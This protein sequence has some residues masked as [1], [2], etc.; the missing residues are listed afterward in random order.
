VAGA[1]SLALPLRRRRAAEAPASWLRRRALR[2]L[3]PETAQLPLDA[4]DWGQG[5]A[6]AGGAA[7]RERLPRGA[8]VSLPHGAFL[9]L[10]RILSPSCSVFTTGIT[11]GTPPQLFE[12][13]VDT[14]SVLLWVACGGCGSDCEARARAHAALARSAPVRP[15]SRAH[16]R[17]SRS[18]HRQA[19]LARPGFGQG[20]FLNTTASA[21]FRAIPCLSLDCITDTCAA[22]AAVMAAESN[23]TLG[24]QPFAAASAL[25]G[26]GAGGSLCGY[27]DQYADGS[28]S[29]GALVNDVLSLGAVTLPVLFGCETA[30]TGNTYIESLDGI[31]GLG[32][33]DQSVITQLTSSGEMADAFALCLGPIGAEYTYAPVQL[34]WQSPGAAAA[35]EDLGTV[36]GAVVFGQLALDAASSGDGEV[37]W[38]PLVRSL[39]CW[40]SYLVSVTAVSAGDTNIAAFSELTELEM[41]AEYAQRCGGTIIDSGSSFM[42]MPTLA[43]E[44]LTQAIG[45]ALAPG[46]RAG[47]C[48]PAALGGSPVNAT[49]YLVPPASGGV[50]AF[51]PLLTVA[52][53]GGA[54][55]SIGPDNYL[56]PLGA[57]WP[58]VYVLGVYDSGGQGV[59]LGAIALAN[60]LVVFDRAAAR[61]GFR[62]GSVD[63]AA[64]AAGQGAVPEPPPAPPLRWV[65]PLPIGARF[66]IPFGAQLILLGGCFTGCFL[67]WLFE[68]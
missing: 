25:V 58:D 15:R 38:S 13:V 29:A 27:Y 2:S 37:L 49:C 28:T 66:V 32:L 53:G 6:R 16:A 64:F 65:N 10:M 22:S 55:L 68:Y 61:V 21:S 33:G 51:F 14:G 40:T 18:T 8:C 43:L 7:L 54:Q 42:Y 47:G 59:V 46:A 19:P 9:G 63:C 48:P 4:N 20:A 62:N 3:Q 36:V 31:M 26:A 11:L 34:P 44:A 50:A 67:G 60:T 56:F 12:V 57:G 24:M 17:P 45:A 41:Q 5:C 30:A 23:V 39:S 52:L 1:P 35:A